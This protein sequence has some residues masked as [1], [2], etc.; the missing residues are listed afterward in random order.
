MKKIIISALFI[1]VA[2]GL[3]VAGCKKKPTD[4]LVVR[5]NTDIVKYITTVQVGDAAKTGIVPGNVTVTAGGPDAQY[6]YSMFGKKNLIVGSDGLLQIAIDPLRVPSTGNPINFTLS[7]SSAGYLPVTTTININAG[8]VRTH[9][10]VRMIN[11]AN[12]PAG[13]TIKEQDMV[14]GSGGIAAPGIFNIAKTTQ[15]TTYYDNG[16]STIVMPQGTT[17]YYYTANTTNK[18]VKGT[19]EIPITKDSVVK[20]GDITHTYTRLTG[21]YQQ[22]YS[23]LQSTTTYTKTPY[24]GTVKTICIYEPGTSVNYLFYPYDE[25]ST[26]TYSPSINLLNGTTTTED[27]LLFATAVKQKLVGVYF[28]GTVTP[29]GA[30][31]PM[32][33][34]ISPDSRYKWFTSFAISDTMKNPITGQLIKEGDSIETG[35]DPVSFN[36][37]RTVVLKGNNG[38][39]RVETQSPDAGF[40]YKAPYSF[41]YAASFSSGVDTNVIP[42][43]ENLRGIASINFAN[44]YYNYYIS[45][46]PGAGSTLNLAMTVNSVSPIVQNGIT[47]GAYYWNKAITSTTSG[48]IFAAPY[49]VNLNPIV[50]FWLTFDC[51]AKNSAKAYNPTYCGATYASTN[52]NGWVSFYFNMINGHWR[53][54]GVQQGTTYTLSSSVCDGSIVTIPF[55]ISG[56]SVVKEYN[57]PVICNCYF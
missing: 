49:L 21:Y 52:T 3:I 50:D 35:I 46:E 19:Q 29:T 6:V 43:I 2:V 55:A 48:A 25:N 32:D 13:M 7:I 28:V 11:L 30:A 51:G 33:I 16:V 36:T 44:Y 15:D 41:H 54:R 14:A 27:N 4:N 38:K 40:Y 56:S 26:N 22:E 34:V 9:Y 37:L 53:T 5:V 24:T 57:D 47:G 12:P 45:P 8:Q 31:S 23:Y 1:A 42:D 17:F 20:Y 18:T 10:N 39:L